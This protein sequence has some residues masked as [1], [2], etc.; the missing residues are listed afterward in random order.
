[1]AGPAV[2]ALHCILQRVFDLRYHLLIPA[3]NPSP[4][5]CPLNEKCILQLQWASMRMPSANVQ[6][7]PCGQ[8]STILAPFPYH[9]GRDSGAWVPNSNCEVQGG[10]CSMVCLSDEPNPQLQG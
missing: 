7:I 2:E 8:D 5:A 9:G 6:D 1:M 3:I 10:H 4:P